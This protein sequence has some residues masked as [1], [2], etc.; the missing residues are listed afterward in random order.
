MKRQDDRTS[1]LKLAV[2]DAGA[3]G[4]QLVEG[5]HRNWKERRRVDVPSLDI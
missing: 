1:R 4:V 5:A 2:R 3:K